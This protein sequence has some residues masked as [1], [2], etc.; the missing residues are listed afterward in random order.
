MGMANISVLTGIN[1]GADNP[2]VSFTVTVISTPPTDDKSSAD[3]KGEPVSTATGELYR[4]F[5]PD[6]SLGG[7][8]TLEFRRYYASLL[9]TN[10]P[11][12]TMGSNWTNNFEWL[13]I[14]NNTQA[15][16]FRFGGRSIQF[17]KGNNGWQLANPEQYGYQLQ[18][19]STGFKFLDPRTNLIYNFNGT[20]GSL[21]PSSIMDRNGNTLTITSSA[22]MSVISDGLGR[23]LTLVYDPTSKNLVKVTDQ[24]GR[25]IS[26]NYSSGNASQFTDANGNVTNYSYSAGGGLLASEARPA[27]NVP[28]TQK[29]DATGRVASQADSS[30]NATTFNYA[31]NTTAYSDPLGATVTDT[32]KNLADFTSYSDADNQTIS[33]LYDGNERR[34]TI[35]DRLG[36]KVIQTYDSV[37]GYIASKTNAAGNKTT[38]SYIPQAAEGFTFY[39][40]SR[41]Q[42]ADNSTTNFAYDTNGNATAVTDQAGKI[43]KFTY[44]QISV[45]NSD[46]NPH[47]CKSREASKSLGD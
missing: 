13:L 26:F 19:S 23:T 36:D 34:T 42:Y 22:G 20:G 17:A 4:A 15:Q 3:K 39:K 8:L 6:I 16:L 24:T 18:N 14:V 41:V 5:A 7:P 31:T 11:P 40:M 44:P 46:H 25:S 38:Y 27:G 32:S 1:G 43:W 35:T 12:T 21:G 45:S 10:R 30:G 2:L 9:S 33:V 47:S 29:F 28:F 37:S